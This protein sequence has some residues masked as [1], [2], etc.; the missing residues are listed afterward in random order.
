MR[1]VID[2]L[3]EERAPWLRRRGPGVTLLRPLLHRLLMYERTVKVG[4]ALEPPAEGRTLGRRAAGHHLATSR[5][6]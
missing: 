4:E 3:I 2:Q 1:E 5:V 6:A